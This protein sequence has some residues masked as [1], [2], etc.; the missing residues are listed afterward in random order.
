MTSALLLAGSALAVTITSFTPKAG[1]AEDQPYCPG[2]HVT[3]TGT[4]FV[5][6]GGVTAV[7]FGG[8]VNAV[9]VQVGSD[10]TIN[11]MVPKG[12]KTGPITVTTRAGTAS[13]QTLNSASNVTPIGEISLPNNL[14]TVNDC[15]GRVAYDSAYGAGA[16]TAAAATTTAAKATVSS[17]SPTRG[18]AGAKVT[19]TGSNFTGATAVKF[20]GVKATFKVASA[21]KI[22]ANVPSGA[23]T[24]KI[25]VTTPAGTATSKGTFTKL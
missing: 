20:A 3:I 25:N 13:T 21:T 7:T 18:K 4:G 19:I 12:A 8:G 1:L 14:F 6:D 16:T 15:W 5:S 9:D 11:V 22:T 23:K 2:G 10:N 17:F 24:G